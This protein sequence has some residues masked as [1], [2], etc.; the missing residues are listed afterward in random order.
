L[1]DG[2]SSDLIPESSD[3]RGIVPAP[4]AFDVLWQRFAPRDAIEPLWLLPLVH[5]D[6][7]VGAALFTAADDGI[8][9]FRAAR[10]ECAALSSA[11]GMA[12]SSVAARLEAERMTEELVDLNRRFRAAEMELVRGRSVSMIAAMAAGAAHEINNPLSVISG[13]AQL[14]LASCEDSDVRQKLETI[15]DQ[16]HRA[17]EIVTDLM[18]FA[19]PNPPE[20]VVQNLL[21]VFDSLSQHWRDGSELGGREITVSVGDEGAAVYADPDQLREL[22][23]AVIS[24]AVEATDPKTGRLQINSA[25]CPSDETVRIVV[26]DDGGGM[27]PD[28]LE[29]AVDPFFSSRPAGRGRGLGLSRAYRL[30]EING[31]RLWL[32]STLNVGTIVTIELPARAPGD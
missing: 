19:K 15:V 16:T 11:M 13:R 8:A 10:A 28:V 31:G 12:V 7:Y 17:A 32:E 29:H 30:A 23:N 2:D 18:D 3:A 14:L 24:N 25:S 5:G 27:T 6:T 4:Q 20:P 9:R 1:G 22:L 26:E 21:Q